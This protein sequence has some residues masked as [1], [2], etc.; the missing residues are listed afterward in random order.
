MGLQKDETL[1]PEIKGFPE[2]ALSYPE[3]RYMGSK[4]RLLPWIHSIL[5]GLSFQTAADPFSGSGCVSYLLK[6]MGKE[7]SSS[8]FLNFPHVISRALVANQSVVL[9]P[10]E[11][12]AL[13]APGM[14]KWNFVS[15]TFKGKGVSPSLNIQSDDR[16]TSPSIR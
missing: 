12:D 6:A 16:Q 14:P 10:K 13:V 8:D 1:F 9:T 11:M 5:A 3:F 7:V 2:Q 15:E 4:H